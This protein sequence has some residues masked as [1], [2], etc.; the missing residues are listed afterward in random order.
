MNLKNV[1]YEA[2]VEGTKSID[3]LG[4][5]FAV[6]CIGII[7]FVLYHWIV[8]LFNAGNPKSRKNLNLFVSGFLSLVLISVSFMAVIGVMNFKWKSEKAN[9][10]IESI[11][12]DK[13]NI[14]NLY[15]VE[16]DKIKGK[17]T[18][19]TKQTKDKMLPLIVTF[20]DGDIKKLSG[21]YRI[22]KTLE[23]GQTPYV[24]YQEL[25]KPIRYFTFISHKH[26]NNQFSGVDKGLYNVKVFVPKDYKL[27]F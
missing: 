27:D 15:I 25:K 4:V 14:S 21:K 5:I 16:E 19:Y 9:P 7:I 11:Q 26:L 10:Y 12:V 24:E 18:L 3:I 22:V 8:L 6:L 20:E 2:V 23:N 1:S 13:K 17:A